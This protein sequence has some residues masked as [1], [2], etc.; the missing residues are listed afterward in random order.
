MIW[1]QYQE[2]LENVSIGKEKKNKGIP[3]DLDA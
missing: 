3:G 2:V 1:G